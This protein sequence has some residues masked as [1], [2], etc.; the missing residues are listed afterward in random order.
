MSIAKIIESYVLGGCDKK[1]FS[2]LLKGSDS[3]EFLNCLHI[4][5]TSELLT[6][7]EKARIT[8]YISNFH[9][10]ENSE[11]IE[12][13]Y[14]IKKYEEAKNEEEKAGIIDELRNKLKIELQEF[15]PY[16]IRKNIKPGENEIL[17]PFAPNALSEKI[18]N[19]YTELEKL[20]S[21]QL[22]ITDFNISEILPIIHFDRLQ[23]KD[24]LYI[25]L[26]SQRIPGL[27]EK[28]FQDRLVLLMKDIDIHKYLSNERALENLSLAQMEFVNKRCKKLKREEAFVKRYLNKRFGQCFIKLKN[29]EFNEETDKYLR[30]IY[31]Y[32]TTLPKMFEGL[33][34]DLL[35]IMLGVGTQ[36]SINIYVYIL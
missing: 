4:L 26:N 12:Y 6:K 28:D 15:P 30:E 33:M 36:L 29:M 25:L 35:R 27:S 18:L 17:Q 32:I 16:E 7:E 3:S 22:P 21:G 20:Y 8:R 1:A 13:R 14:I 19:I 9:N 11:K 23:W 34:L 24:F 10:T 31:E 5:N 2:G